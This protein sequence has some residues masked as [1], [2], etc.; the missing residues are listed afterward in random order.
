M[1]A[2]KIKKSYKMKAINYI[3]TVLIIVFFAG[4]SEDWLELKNPNRPTIENFFKTEQDFVLATNAIYQ[5]LYYDGSYMRF[6]P[7]AIDL[8]GDDVKGD[9]PWG[10]IHNTG[11]F[12]L[13]TNDIMFEWPWVV[14]F[15]GVHRANHVI[16]RIDNIEWEDQTLHDQLLGQ[17]LFLRGLYYFHLVC[18][19]NNIPL[20]L[21]PY[22][23]TD[24]YYPSQVPPEDVWDQIIEDLQAAASLL[25]STWSGSDLGRATKGAAMGYLGKAYLF[26]QEWN[27]AATQF[28]NVMNLNIYGL[29]D[30]YDHNFTREFE[31]NKESIFEIQFDRT[32][33]GTV[34]GWVDEPGNDWSKTSARAITYGAEN[35]G[36]SDVEPTPW[37]FNE[38]QVE[39]DT[40]G[41]VDYRLECTIMYNYPGATLYGIP[42][43]EAY[44]TD[45]T[46]IWPSKYENDDDPE[47]VSIGNEFDWRSGINERL[48]RYSDILLMYA[49]CQNELGDQATC[50]QYIQVVRDR[51]GLPDREAE[52]AGYTQAQMRE[53]IAHERALEFSFE[54]HRF[55]DIRRWGWLS[56]PVKLEELKAH[57]E[58]FNSYVTGREFFAIPQQ[59]MDSNP[60]ARQNQGY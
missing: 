37:I 54:G 3:L 12:A 57:D 31:N 60:N 59:E 19:F 10:T 50:A 39:P 23:S 14:F 13:P 2:M 45:T 42:F 56:D 41:N 8:K 24:A 46:R 28:Q 53:Q 38:F 44:P 36:F 6:A 51:V 16:T 26:N 17:A 15:G 35:F 1:G 29:M 33:G 20:I 21:E 22:E 47:Y 58:E 30:D 48:M 18:F 55:D 40:A 4:C 5:S 9:S 34:L 11:R 32:V 52:F 49:E 43:K 25:P 27:L 7:L